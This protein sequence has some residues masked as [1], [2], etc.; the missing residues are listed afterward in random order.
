MK[1]FWLLDL[2]SV[3]PNIFDES[4][5]RINIMDYQTQYAE[6][7][8]KYNM[9]IRTY[10][11]VDTSKSIS[12]ESMTRLQSNSSL[13]R[14]ERIFRIT[15]SNFKKYSSLRSTTDPVNVFKQLQNVPNTI[16]IRHGKLYEGVA[17]QH[18]LKVQNVFDSSA[19][20]GQVGFVVHPS[21]PFLGASPD[22]VVQDKG[23][24]YLLEIKCP[25]SCFINKKTIKESAK[26]SSFFLSC[27]DDQLR[28]NKT[29]S[30]FLQIQGQLH[31]C[32][33]KYA[34]LVVFVPPDDIEFV[35]VEK[36]DVS[37]VF[38][39]LTEVWFNSLLPHFF[40]IFN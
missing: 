24:I 6:C 4:W 38:K 27:V 14:K 20:S 7:I 32:N 2:E 33:L 16:A 36:E 12:I 30:V 28:I 25:Y 21:A 23:C 8:Q 15:A 29:H 9:F 3:G 18:F 35:L 37:S 5:S 17:I 22:Y 19:L 34:Y 31:L 39:T 13:W 10:I 26:K 1:I 11:L 40:S